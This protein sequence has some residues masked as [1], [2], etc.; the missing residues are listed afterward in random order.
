MA[1]GYVVRLCRLCRRRLTYAPTSYTASHDDH[2]NINSL[3][4]MSIEL[5]KNDSSFDAK[6]G[7]IVETAEDVKDKWDLQLTQDK[8]FVHDL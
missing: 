3:V 4:P 7:H 2:E 5:Y 1:K 6:Q 8:W